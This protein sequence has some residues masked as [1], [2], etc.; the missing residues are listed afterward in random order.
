VDNFIS[1]NE[2]A[3]GECYPVSKITK[4]YPIG[5]GVTKEL[6]TVLGSYWKEKESVQDQCYI[7]PSEF[8]I[9]SDTGEIIALSYSDGGLGRIDA[10][11]VVG[12]VAGRENMKDNVPHVWPWGVDPPLDEEK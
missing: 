1:A 3:K 8:L 12:F 4:S 10:R 5:Y 2:V 6:A 7:Q 11:D 9:E